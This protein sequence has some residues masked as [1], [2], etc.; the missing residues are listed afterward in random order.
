MSRTHILS[1]SLQAQKM[2]KQKNSG[3]VNFG[4]LLLFFLYPLLKV[5]FYVQFLLC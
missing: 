4:K 5:V 2:E 1:K 3:K